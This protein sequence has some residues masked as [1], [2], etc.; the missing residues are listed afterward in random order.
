MQQDRRMVIV[1]QGDAVTTNYDLWLETPCDE[2]GGHVV[3]I[4][5]PDTTGIDAEGPWTWVYRA[6]GE[7]QDRLCGCGAHE[8][9]KDRVSRI[10]EAT[11]G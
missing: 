10:L 3:R 2:H 9:P 7:A 1:V 11:R 6:L 4:S 8:A 5:D